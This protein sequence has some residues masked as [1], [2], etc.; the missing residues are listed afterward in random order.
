MS[1]CKTFQ[2]CHDLIVI[3]VTVIIAANLTHFLKRINDN[4][5]RVLMLCHKSCKLFIQSI[6]K[7]TGRNREVKI[8]GAFCSK[9]PVQTLLQTAV[10][11][12]KCQIQHRSFSGGIIP[13]R[14]ACAD[15]VGKLCHQKALSQFGRT[16]KDISA[17]VE[18][19]VNQRLLTPILCVKQFIHGNSLEIGR[20]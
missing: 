11:I 6:S 2:S 10:I 20:V 16:C 5:L 17:G 8:I 15:M 4:Q 18:Q 9:H 7:L 3:C 14:C 12:L 13:K 19:T 1:I